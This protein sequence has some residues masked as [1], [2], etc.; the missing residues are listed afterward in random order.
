MI[1]FESESSFLNMLLDSSGMIKLCLN[2]MH[3]SKEKEKKNK[4]FE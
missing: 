2:D 1:C 4:S 3:I